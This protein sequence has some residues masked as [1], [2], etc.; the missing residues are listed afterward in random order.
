MDVNYFIDEWIWMSTQKSTMAMVMRLRQHLFRIFH[1]FLIYCGNPGKFRINSTILKQYHLL[2]EVLNEICKLEDA[3]LNFKSDLHIGIRPILKLP[4][5]YLHNINTHFMCHQPFG[6][7]TMYNVHNFKIIQRLVE[8]HYFLLYTDKCCSQF[9]ENCDKS[10]I[11]DVIGKFIRP[12][13]SPSRHIYIILYSKNPDIALSISRALI[14]KG[15]V[16]FKEYF[17]NE[18]P[19]YEIR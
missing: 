8:N 7:D 5:S 9:Y 3:A 2:L 16:I 13:S 15:E 1:N 4:S 10:Y 11:E 17:R 19:I 12:I 14:Q 6:K 18:I